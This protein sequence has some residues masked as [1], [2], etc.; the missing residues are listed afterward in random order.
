VVLELLVTVYGAV[1]L[2]EL[3][4][5][6]TLYTVGA[7]AVNG[8][9]AAVLSGAGFAVS[10]KMLAAVLLGKVIADLPPVAV[11]LVSA[12]TFV[13]MALTIWF[14]RPK[15]REA[16]D[17]V[18]RSAL[19]VAA[20]TFAAIFFTEWGDVGQVTCAIFAA[21]HSGAGAIVWLAA[22][23]AMF[24]K[25]VLAATVGVGLQRWVPRAVLRV[26]TAALCL[27][28]GVLSAIAAIGIEV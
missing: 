7:I 2:A 14:K 28:M 15:E 24:T 4:G 8:R 16:L 17:A 20:A 25:V 22:S 27:V 18:P 10:L 9:L 26:V 23:L 12:V 1:L 13:V 5:D 6:K 19:R 21:K 3:L 11:S